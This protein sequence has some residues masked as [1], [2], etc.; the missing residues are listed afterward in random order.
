ML[1]NINEKIYFDTSSSILYTDKKLINNVS[2]ENKNKLRNIFI[3]KRNNHFK[4]HRTIKTLN[5]I[6]SMKCNG[7]CL[8][9]YNEDNNNTINVDMSLETIKDSIN[10]ILL[11]GYSIDAETVRLYGGEPLLCN[12]LFD[13]L[14]YL[15]DKYE[16]LTIYI[17]SGLYIDDN[18]F[19]YIVD[20]IKSYHNI[21][22]GVGVDLGTYPET[23]IGTIDKSKLLS[24]CETLLDNNINT[25]LVNTVSKF[26]NTDKL[27]NEI[28]DF[29][30]K[31]N[32]AKFRIA[33][34]CDDK[35]S[36]SIE[37]L[38]KLEL[39][40]DSEYSK[41]NFNL[42]SN[43]FPYTDV[44]NAPSIYKIDDGIYY[45][46]YS[47]Y[48]CGIFS[49]MI[50]ILPNGQLI[51]CHMSPTDNTISIDDFHNKELL[52]S[53]EKCKNCDFY[54][55]CRGGCFYRYQ[56]CDKFETNIYCEWIKKSFILS[57]KRLVYGN[58]NINTIIDR[59]S[60]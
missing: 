6:G 57:L 37:Q 34:A 53:N 52:T 9:C 17:S 54:L 18:K 7:K 16:N 51:H 24:R 19:N 5:F 29:K 10:D 60:I 25:I 45:F 23:R 14:D 13:I 27:F 43:I 49:D 21:S 50:N 11:K 48:Y 40:L 46:S 30:S 1:I 33:V 56:I 47:P 38:N 26:T 55:Q 20:R 8:Y 2:D 42:T 31:Y 28:S 35:Y 59:L 15:N 58:N 3:D 32:K 44:I 4:R 39:K 41:Q 36:P 22:I 12:E